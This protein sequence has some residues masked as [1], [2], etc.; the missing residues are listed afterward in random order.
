MPWASQLT[1]CVGGCWA[2]ALQQLWV[3]AHHVCRAWGV[4]RMLACLYAH[5]RAR[6]HAYLCAHM[7]VHV[8]MCAH[9]RAPRLQCAA[10]LSMRQNRQRVCVR[11]LHACMP[12]T[13]AQKHALTCSGR[14]RLA[15]SFGQLILE[16]SVPFRVCNL[17][18]VLQLAP[19]LTSVSIQ[20]LP[21]RYALAA[22][23]QQRTQRNHTSLPL[24]SMMVVG[25]VAVPRPD[26]HRT[27]IRLGAVGSWSDGW[28][29]LAWE[30]EVSGLLLCC[31]L[32]LLLNTPVG[33]ELCACTYSASYACSAFR[34]GSGR[35]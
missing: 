29:S 32:L 20:N 22:T 30:W 7:R 13:Q 33:F 3:C 8:Y 10:R 21:V 14:L 23:Q 12:C 16:A 19:S 4:Q 31:L 26:T 25:W 2:L 17:C 6:V 27:L 11:W 5:M 9:M 24:H 1:R 18:R 35:C 28:G 34:D 15:N